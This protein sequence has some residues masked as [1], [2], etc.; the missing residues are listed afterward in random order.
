MKIS[1]L[2]ISFFDFGFALHIF[3]FPFRFLTCG[4]AKISRSSFVGYISS[5]KPIYYVKDIL[6]RSFWQFRE[7]NPTFSSSVLSQAL[8]P[9]LRL[10]LAC[11]SV[12]CFFTLLIGIKRYLNIPIVCYLLIAIDRWLPLQ[13]SEYRK[14][15]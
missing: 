12:A 4:Y 11:I 5:P 13:K 14:E 7:L 8:S 10:W 9:F 15:A 2:P 1:S 6:T 3:L